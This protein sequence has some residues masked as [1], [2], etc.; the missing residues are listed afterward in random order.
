MISWAS[1]ELDAPQHP[2]STRAKDGP[3]LL[4]FDDEG[5]S[6][7]LSNSVWISLMTVTFT[8][9]VSTLGGY[10]F[11]RFGKDVARGLALRCGWG[12][13]YIADASINEVKWLGCTISPSYVGEL[14]CN[15]VAERFMRTL[16]EQCIYLHQF[17]SLEE[18]QRIIG[19]FIRG[20]LRQTGFVHALVRPPHVQRHH[21]P[22]KIH[23]ENDVQ[24]GG[25]GFDV[26]VRQPRPGHFHPLPV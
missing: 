26:R 1:I 8:L 16:K 17:A 14:E 18:A 12:L 24:S 10:A 4:R 6:S 13:Q 25:L 20:H 15:G 2:L 22:R 5:L 23:G 9:V 19:E 7:F 21:G 3:K 11:G